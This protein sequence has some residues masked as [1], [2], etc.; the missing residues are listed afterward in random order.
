MHQCALINDSKARCSQLLVRYLN[1]HFQS[2]KYFIYVIL[3]QDNDSKKS[4]NYFLSQIVHAVFVISETVVIRILV[5]R[6]GALKL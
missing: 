3:N 4:K 6:A 5:K 1:L 2:R